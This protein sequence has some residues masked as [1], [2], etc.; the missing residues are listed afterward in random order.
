RTLGIHGVP[1]FVFNRQYA[2]SGAQASDGFLQAL[3]QSWAAWQQENPVAAAQV[4]AG[5]VCT[6]DSDC[7]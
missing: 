7:A 1:F 5:E 2:V 3:E 4:G 6:P